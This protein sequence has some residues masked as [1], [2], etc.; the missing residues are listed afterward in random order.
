MRTTFIAAVAT[1]FLA[2]MTCPS[3]SA[4]HLYASN[5][6]MDG[7]NSQEAMALDND[8]DGRFDALD[9]HVD[10]R[11][12]GSRTRG[13]AVHKKAAGSNNVDSEEP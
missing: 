2:A 5:P 4:I 10:G 7:P 11:Q 13:N 3:A 12:P 6:K 1:A 9:K 8:V